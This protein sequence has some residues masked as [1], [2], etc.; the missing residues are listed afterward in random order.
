[1]ECEEYG[2]DGKRPLAAFHASTPPTTSL[3]R[4][5]R[6]S[7][8]CSLSARVPRAATPLRH[9]EAWLRIF[10]VRCSLPCD[11]PVGGHSCNG[12]MI[13]RFRPLG[14]RLTLKESPARAGMSLLR[15]ESCGDRHD[16]HLS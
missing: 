8:K 3:E 6:L 11:P 16:T 9:R 13:P 12:G 5:R 15:D 1:M 2:D 14:V 10:V 4:R 7:L